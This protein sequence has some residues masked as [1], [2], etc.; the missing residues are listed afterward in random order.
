MESTGSPLTLLRMTVRNL[1]RRPMR[2]SLTTLG[3]AIGVVAIVAFSTIAAG[4]WVSVEEL[5]R[6]NDSDLLVF[7][8]NAA[9][10]ILSTLDEEETRDAL[11]AIPGVRKA[12][13]T[14]WHVLPV[15]GQMFVMLIGLHREDMGSCQARLVDGRD[16]EADGEVMLGTLARRVLKKDVGDTLTILNE[17]YRVAGV[18]ESSNVFVN[19]A[20]VL[21]LAQLQRVAGKEGRVTAFQVYLDPQAD[22]DAVIER[23]ESEHPQLAAV[24]DVS[25]YGKVDQGLAI[26]DGTV[27][28]VSLI[29][30]VVGGIIVANTM[31]MSVLERTREIG[32]LRAVGWSRQKIVSMILLE[33]AGVGLIACAL[34]CAGGA[35]L[36]TVV[37][38]MQIA[39]RFM[40]PVFGL[41]PFLQALIVAVLLSVL[42]A[43]MPAWRAARI[44]PAEALRY[45]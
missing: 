17:P 1:Y 29:A 38:R 40:Q 45:E 12:V 33:A 32:V 16:L 24:A 9:A 23:I 8:A 21:T 31:W 6:F 11:L 2:T 7:Q 25:Q 41:T 35:G 18:F 5:I 3:V 13:G 10:D 19:G 36:A 28:A 27:W 14:L 26:I 15:E 37:T 43:F 4:L 44:S 42:G 39:D 22:A 30:L 34:G 20:V